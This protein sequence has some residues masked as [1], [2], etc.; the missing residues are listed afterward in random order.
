M[1]NRL[2]WQVGP[3][4][5]TSAG[6]LLPGE[7]NREGALRSSKQVVV[8]VDANV[9]EDTSLYAASNLATDECSDGCRSTG[10]DLKQAVSLLLRDQ[11]GGARAA[12]SGRTETSQRSGPL[13]LASTLVARTPA[14]TIAVTATDQVSAAARSGSRR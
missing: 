8:T 5:P 12:G 4:R 7:P 11:R 1:G 10:S 9:P 14:T 13:T 3:L 6:E 2:I